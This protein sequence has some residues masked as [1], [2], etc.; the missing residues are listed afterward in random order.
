MPGATPSSHRPVLRRTTTMSETTF[1][2]RQAWLIYT[3]SKRQYAQAFKGSLLGF[4]S[5]VLYNL[6]M[7]ALYSVVF[8]AILSVRWHRLG[9]EVNAAEVPFWLALLA[10]QTVFLCL[11]ECLTRAPST[12]L[13]VPNYVKKIIFPL[14]LLPLINL[15]TALITFGINLVLVFGATVAVVG[16]SPTFFYALPVTVLLC[17]WALGFGWLFGALGVFV[18][19]LQQVAPILSQMLFFATPIVYPLSMVPERFQ[20][21]L[22]ANPFTFIVETMRACLFWKQAPDW[23]AYGIWTVVALVFAALSFL[24]FQRLRPAFAD[25]M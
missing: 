12:V 18:K 8:S 19:D 17:I 20:W 5:P 11:S 24:V 13:A 4:L 25:V 1:L 9:E 22:H 7:M 15:N 2:S 10:G 3:L 21:I 23:H 14:H 16:F 6:I